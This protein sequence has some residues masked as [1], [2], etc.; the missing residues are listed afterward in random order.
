MTNN[1]DI[2]GLAVGHLKTLFSKI[3]CLRAVINDN[4]KEPIWDG[5]IY[6]YEYNT[7][8]RS[9]EDL[10]G[11]I[12]I[13]VKGHIEKDIY[14]GNNK[15]PSYK[16]DVTN[17]KNYLNDGG[18]LFFVVTFDEN[19]ENE[20][21]FYKKLLPYDLNK[22]LKNVGNKKTKTLP[23][24][25][26]PKNK[27]K[28]IEL[29]FNFI[30]DKQNQKITLDNINFNDIINNHK[31]IVLSFVTFNKDYKAAFD[32][33]LNNDIYIYTKTEYGSLLPIEHIKNVSEVSQEVNADVKIG[34]KVYYTKIKMAFL[35][36]DTVEVRIGKSLTIRAN[37]KE[38]TQKLTFKLSGTLLNEIDDLNFMIDSIK[39]NGFKINENLFDFTQTDINKS[40][41]F[42]IIEMEKY[43]LELCRIKKL[44]EE[45]NVYEELNIDKLTTKDFLNLKELADG[46]L[47]NK[48]I[49]LNTKTTGLGIFNIG[50]LKILLLVIQDEITNKF[51]LCNYYDCPVPVKMNN[52]NTGEVWE[53]P[54]FL[55]LN[56]EYL[57]SISN[58]NENFIVRTLNNMTFTPNISAQV[59]HFLLNIL[60]AYDESAGKKKNLLTLSK[61]IINIIQANDIY[62]PK[63]YLLLNKLQIVK[64]E[65][66]LTKE[67]R[68]ELNLVIKNNSN[69]D[70]FLSGA[71]ILLDEY[72]TAEQHL[73]NLTNFQQK[74]FKTYPIYKFLRKHKEVNNEQTKV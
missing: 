15:I 2:E 20:K 64:R 48:L 58:L 16:F 47:D 24:D 73:K 22:I 14:S 31:N 66:E 21:V 43:L 63:T 33:V 41:G 28:I 65:R 13:Q 56:K 6:V 45:C 62:L 60:N 53:C 23:L 34:E 18:V 49:E 26:L 9:N 1:I 39:N 72:Y 67:E 4:D 29:F 11:R 61:N 36:A 12:P 70:F 50:N 37:M 27:E 44:L 40:S 42:N 30:N 69:D 57:K 32:Y 74:E 19:G 52:N 54:I 38:K 59:S 51:Q 17:L 7:K 71:Y 8:Q 55:I 3:G 35:P 5:Y 10:K 25:F 68:Y 46:I